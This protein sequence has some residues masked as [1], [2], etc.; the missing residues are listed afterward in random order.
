MDLDLIRGEIDKI[1]DE[2]VKLLEKRAQ[3]AC[4]VARYKKENNMQVFQQT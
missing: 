1:D 3:L 2:L 4:D